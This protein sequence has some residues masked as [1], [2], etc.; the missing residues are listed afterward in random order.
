MY[1]EIREQVAVKGELVKRISRLERQKIRIEELLYNSSGNMTAQYNEVSVQSSTKR[2]STLALMEDLATVINKLTLARE[3]FNEVD[4]Y[5]LGVDQVFTKL[6]DKEK[7]IYKEKVIYGL[8]SI[9]I[10]KKLGQQAP[11][12]GITDRQVRYYLAAI[13]KKYNKSKN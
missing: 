1:D 2:K 12:H 4:E 11:Y 7:I 8:N 9:D 13:E 10:A 5:L 6:N 3:E